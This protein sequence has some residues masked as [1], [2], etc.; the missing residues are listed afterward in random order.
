MM[1]KAHRQMPWPGKSWMNPK[2]Q[3]RKIPL[4]SVKSWNVLHDRASI[5]AT[6]ADLL[7]SQSSDVSAFPFGIGHVTASE[8]VS[9][10]PAGAHTVGAFNPGCWQPCRHSSSF[11]SSWQALLVLLLPEE[12]R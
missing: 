11:H 1:I 8:V 2:S 7:M 5:P 10:V 12:R 3:I 4:I 9:L 6:T